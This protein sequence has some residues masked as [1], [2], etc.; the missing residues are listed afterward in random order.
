MSIGT[1][2]LN[3]SHKK[4]PAGMPGPPFAANSARNGLSVDSSGHIVFGNDVGDGTAPAKLLNNRFVPMEGFDID[5]NNGTIHIEGIT[6]DPGSGPLTVAD[7]ES[8]GFQAAYIIADFDPLVI[9]SDNAGGFPDILFTFGDINTTGT[10]LGSMGANTAGNFLFMDARN[11]GALVF[12]TNLDTRMTIDVN[13]K[14]DILNNLILGILNPAGA[15]P[16]TPVGWDTV[17]GELLANNDPV[18]DSL[19]VTDNAGQSAEIGPQ[20]LIFAT[21]DAD[22]L[23]HSLAIVFNNATRSATIIANNDPSLGGD[24]FEVLFNASAAMRM[25]ESGNFLFS[26]SSSG[27]L[28]DSGS[29]AQFFGNVDVNGGLNI[30]GGNIIPEPNEVPW[31]GDFSHYFFRGFINELHTNSVMNAAAQ[32]VSGNATF[33]QPE[34]GSS[35]KKVIIYC[36]ALTGAQSYTFPAAFTHTPQIVLTNGPAAGIVTSLSTSAVTVTGTATTGFIILEGF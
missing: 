20:D 32:T 23:T 16:L 36:N 13:G 30:I 7:P 8:G 4:E 35:Y 1:V 27:A 9:R 18:F 3:T 12:N 10:L 14:V 6:G 15:N 24:L 33:S 22:W 2:S 11:G 21:A 17:T 19:L 31:L 28:S 29:L 5:F 34:Q 26:N 25:L